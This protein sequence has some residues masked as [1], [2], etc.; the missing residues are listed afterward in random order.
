MKKIIF[1][2]IFIITTIQLHSQV[3][4]YSYEDLDLFYFDPRHSY[5]IPHAAG[6]FV[7]A[8]EFHK[9]FWD[10]TPSEDVQILLNDFSDDGNGGTIVIPW[11]FISLGIAP[12]EYTFDVIPSNERMQWLMNHEL[13][14]VVMCDK[15]SPGDNFWR[16]IFLGKVGQDPNDP[17][18]MVYSYLTT[19]RWYSPRWYHEGIAVFME[20][21]MSGGLGRTL[22]GYDEMVFRS[23][24]LDSAYFYRVVGLETEG[25]TI[26]FQ[27]G[28]NAYLYGTRFIAWLAKTYGVEKVRA[29]YSRTDDSDKFY[30]SQFEKVFNID[31]EDAWEN[32]IAWE[33]EHQKSN[34][35]KVNKYPVTDFRNITSEPLG[36]VSRPFIDSE[37]GKIIVAVNYPGDMA[38]VESIDIETGQRE[39]ICEIITPKL[40]YVTS[41]CYDEVSKTVFMA[42]TNNNWR[43]LSKYNIKTDEK[44]YLI[45]TTRAGDFAL[46]NKDRSLWAVQNMSGRT[47][48]IRIPPPYNTFDI[49][50]TIPYGK[51][52]FDIDVSPDGEM[53]SATWSEL[54]GR[55]SLVCFN[56]RE[57]I[58]GNSDKRTLFEFEDNSVSNFVFSPD[59]TK[60]Y[61]TSYYTGIS[62]VF[63]ID[64]ETGEMQALSNA[65]AGLF[66]PTPVGN[67]SLL[68]FKYTRNGMLPV[69]TGINPIEDIEPIDYLGQMVV[70][71]NP[72]VKEWALEPAAKAVMLDRNI[73]SEE[74]FSLFTGIGLASGYP[75]VEGYKKYAA[76]GYKLNFRDPLGMHNLQ[77]KSSY[78]ANSNLPEK[79]RLHAGIS[80]NYW[81]W[82]I[83]AAYNPADF[84][85]LFGPVKLGRAGWFASVKYHKDLIYNHKPHHS[86]FYLRLS[87]YGDLEKMPS[88]QNV[89]ASF[90]KL[91]TATAQFHRN[92]FRKSLGSIEPESGYDI[93]IWSHTNLANEEFYPL[94]FGQFDFGGLLP[95][96]NSSI[97]LRTA[98][99][100]SLKDDGS[101]F[102]NF[103][104]GGFGNNYIDRFN[105]QDMKNS[106]YLAVKK[107]RMLESFPGRDLNELEG[108]NFVKSFAEVNFTPIRFRRLGFLYMY[109]TY[110]QFSCFAGGIILNPDKDYR[111]QVYN[112]GGQLDFQVVFFSLLKTTL[113]FGYA[114]SFE[115]GLRPDEEFMISLK[116]L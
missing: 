86:D 32:W 112:I 6:T 31:V 15:A 62:N 59:G 103:Y 48:L 109:S 21:W 49:I 28:V 116:L 63:A 3:M 19:P 8:M 105:P 16:S 33:K 67:D 84:Y 17:L 115:N 89:N 102:G 35:E 22:G 88:Y 95:M 10:Y 96:R 87:A 56:I 52:L 101:P 12:F 73:A 42:E 20:T 29:F 14:H 30:A 81:D 82:Y 114:R 76:F 1:T 79:E 64:V 38:H 94:L 44:E 113:S 106:D 60:L 5:L 77:L 27:V 24:Y 68:V 9:K 41:L 97:W 58:N 50:F 13:V 34:I 53:L 92:F 2:V 36:T 104:F 108:R 107:Y 90:D 55:Q 39:R 100:H 23:M 72:I 93:K 37:T 4:E 80:Y 40:N 78:T 66:R 98:A 47:S 69:M 74:P 7:N 110:A 43:G 11:N 111:R 51:S 91:Y 83:N 46:N 54:S 61:G 70:E 85:D 25:T 99:G 57:L 18:S 45:E 26:D 65:E 71:K 75:I